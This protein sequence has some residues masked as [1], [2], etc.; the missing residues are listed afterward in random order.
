M[1]ENYFDGT[2]EKITLPPAW[3]AHA[4]TCTGVS[5]ILPRCVAG[6]D[7]LVAALRRLYGSGH[8]HFLG[9]G[10]FNGR[11]VDVFVASGGPVGVRSAGGF[12]RRYRVHFR[13]LVNARTLMPAEIQVT[14]A[15]GFTSIIEQ[16]QRLPITA[17]N[18]KL[19]GLRAHPHAR[20]ITIR[21]RTMA[22]R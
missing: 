6:T 15:G 9:Q 7:D 11:R 17:G 3:A 19:L 14:S 4:L 13:V 1:M 10:T 12:S 18:E 22:S 21:P 2:I 5:A 20:V 8:I 16:F